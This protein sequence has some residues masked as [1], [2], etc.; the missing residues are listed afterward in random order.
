MIVEIN[1]YELETENIVKFYPCDILGNYQEQSNF[2]CIESK[3]GFKG[4]YVC[5][6]AELL[7]KI[8]KGGN[9]DCILDHLNRR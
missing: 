5:N 6:A 3:D 8:E 1:S 9:A 7:E 2:T 4:I